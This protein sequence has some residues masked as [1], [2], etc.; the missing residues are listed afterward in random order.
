MKNVSLR[1]EKNLH[2]SAHFPQKVLNFLKKK[3]VQFSGNLFQDPKKCQHN[4]KIRR[5]FQPILEHI[6]A[7]MTQKFKSIEILQYF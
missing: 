6:L 5:N 7:L 3:S 1:F 4:S 2:F